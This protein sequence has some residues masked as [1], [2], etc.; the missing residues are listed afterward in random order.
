MKTA[1]VILNWNG[2]QHLQHS[3]PSVVSTTPDADI[4]VANYT[5]EYPTRS[6]VQR[7]QF[8]EG[9]AFPMSPQE[10]LR[11]LH[12]RLAIFPFPWNKIYR[13]DLLRSIDF[14]TGNFVG[15]DYYM[16]LML[17][18]TVTKIDYADVDGYHYVLTENSASRGG[19][20]PATLLAFNHF[21]EGKNKRRKEGR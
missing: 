10:A 20:G 6:C 16:Q 18:E 1:V 8:K 2:L 3:L 11:Y 7:N 17:Y 4:V 5:E 12:R 21:K 9:Q 15:E 14:P 19:Y 13:A